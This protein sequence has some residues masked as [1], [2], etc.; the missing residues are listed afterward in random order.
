M[1]RHKN[2]SDNGSQTAKYSPHL[3]SSLSVR[4]ARDYVV[5]IQQQT[6]FPPNVV[7]GRGFV[8]IVTTSDVL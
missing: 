5:F 2:H 6:L 1:N 3:Q 8:G 4:S 7:N